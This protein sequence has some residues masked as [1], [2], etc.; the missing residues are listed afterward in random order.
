[1]PAP[2][3]P[4]PAP[5]P[6]GVSGGARSTV[7]VVRQRV[8]G[9]KLTPADR[10]DLAIE[11]PLEMEIVHRTSE[12]GETRRRVVTMRT[13]GHDE[14]LV[15]GFLY[16]EGIL[17][18]AADLRALTFPEPPGEAA[19]RRVR[20]ILRR[21]IA[22]AAESR[23]PGLA[24]NASCGVC[25]SPSLEALGL[26]PA[27][28]LDDPVRLERALVHELPGRMRAEQDTF[29]RTGGLHAAAIFS[30]G[31]ELLVSREDI[32]R[33]NALDKAVGHLL[34]EGRLP[35]RGCLLC[36]SG[37]MSYEILQKALRARIPVV[38]GVGAPSSL[39]VALANDFG[40][41]LCGF[42]RGGTY[43]IYSCPERLGGPL[44]V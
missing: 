15:Y 44:P 31:G 5:F 39:A 37:R 43:N 11:D 33:H 2:A 24:L 13:P 19:P 36:V 10:D 18:T 25:G 34:R 1:M 26:S 12:E 30:S 23:D 3:V 6:E 7:G 28:V 14:D 22:P 32:G 35:A 40:V 20:A 27:L 38:A 41:T 29:R 16:A 9:A 21:G 8:E 4:E 42:V 17:R